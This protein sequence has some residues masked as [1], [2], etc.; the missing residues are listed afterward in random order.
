MHKLA[1]ESELR[2]SLKCLREQLALVDA[3]IAALTRYRDTSRQQ[4]KFRAPLP[5][6]LIRSSISAGQAE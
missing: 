4:S 1:D 6:L 2:W 3:A 5:P